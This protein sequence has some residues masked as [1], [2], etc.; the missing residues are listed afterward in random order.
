MT[1]LDPTPWLHEN[2]ARYAHC[3][4]APPGALFYIP[5]KEHEKDDTK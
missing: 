5:R 4:Q 1:D 2:G 3:D